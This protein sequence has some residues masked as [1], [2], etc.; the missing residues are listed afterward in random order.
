MTQ[1]L[2]KS[3][4]SRP[5]SREYRDNYDRTFGKAAA[6]NCGGCENHDRETV[7]DFVCTYSGDGP[8]CVGRDCEC[9]ECKK[10][11]TSQLHKHMHKKD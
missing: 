5:A 8:E 4:S 7:H 3:F 9:V 6:E 2:N 11:K 1:F 10:P